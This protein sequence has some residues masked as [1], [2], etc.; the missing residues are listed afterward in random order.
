M[1]SLMLWRTASS[2]MEDDSMDGRRQWWKTLFQIGWILSPSHTVTSVEQLRHYLLICVWLDT[3]L[4][5]D[6][7]SLYSFI[8]PTLPISSR[9]QR[10]IL[11]L[12]VP[13]HIVQCFLYSFVCVSNVW[14]ARWFWV[15]RTI[16][17]QLLA[18]KQSWKKITQ[19]KTMLD[20]FFN[21]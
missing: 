6:F 13:L 7:Y 17:V 21:L 19:L 12:N 20:C 1:T 9:M 16:K 14:H 2:L 18:K 11:H 8:P 5:N 15:T 4:L 10:E 3:G